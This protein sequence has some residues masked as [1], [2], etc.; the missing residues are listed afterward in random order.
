M[1]VVDTTV[2]ADWFNGART[3]EGDRLDRAL[4]AQEAGLTPVILTEVLQGFRADAHFDRARALLVRLPVLELDT[5]GHVA[6]AALFR[7]LRRKV[8]RHLPARAAATVRR[9]PVMR[10]P[11]VAPGPDGPA[12]RALAGRGLRGNVSPAVR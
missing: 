1:I 9:R 2:W 8:R 5:S 3:P 12:V 7:L 4:T 10:R 6:A 11:A